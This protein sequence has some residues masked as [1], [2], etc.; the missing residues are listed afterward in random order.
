MAAQEI[1]VPDIGDFTDVPII[2]IHVAPGDTVAVTT[3]C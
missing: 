3:R 1:S 2:E